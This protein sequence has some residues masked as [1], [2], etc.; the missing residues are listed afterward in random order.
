MY[1]DLGYNYDW[2]IEIIDQLHDIVWSEVPY[3][4]IHFRNMTQRIYHYYCV[5]IK[6]YSI[7]VD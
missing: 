1:E 5:K 4:T 7:V 3:I 6:F 2:K